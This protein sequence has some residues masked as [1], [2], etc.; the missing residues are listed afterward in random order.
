MVVEQPIP[1]DEFEHLETLV[2][3]APVPISLDESM[4]VD[5]E[6]VLRIPRLWEV[7]IKPMFLG[8]LCRAFG[9]AK[10]AQ[11]KGLKVCITH[12]LES[13]IGRLGA[14]HLASAI[15]MEHVHG[16]G[17]GRHLRKLLSVHRPDQGCSSAGRGRW[18]PCDL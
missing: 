12:A 4:V 1:A 13:P 15:G 10:R 18:A 14:L 2:S 3:A 5:A 8:G 17:G 9:L 6:R 11:E 7:V 16:V